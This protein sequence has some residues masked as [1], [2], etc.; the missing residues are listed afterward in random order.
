ME[1]RIITTE[2]TKSG[3]PAL[4]EEGGATRNRGTS[5]IIAGPGGERLSPAFVR[6]KGHLSNISHA[7]FSL[8]RGF[9]VIEVSQDHGAVRTEVI[10][11]DSF[12]ENPGDTSTRL[13]IGFVARAGEGNPYAPEDGEIYHAVEAAIAKASTYHCRTALWVNQEERK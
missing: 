6:Q 8:K 1:Q 10:V 11:I 2:I 12:R 9:R 5:R 4:W 7:L 3:R 13:A